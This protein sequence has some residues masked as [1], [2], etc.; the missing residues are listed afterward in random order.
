M[1]IRNTAGIKK[2]IQLDEK[3]NAYLSLYIF[4]RKEFS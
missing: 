1:L 4:K 3:K 2:Y